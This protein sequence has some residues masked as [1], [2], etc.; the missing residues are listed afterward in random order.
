MSS[1]L[2]EGPA[3]PIP[4]PRAAVLSWSG[5]KD[6]SLALWEARRLGWG[7]RWLL[8]TVTEA[9][10]RVSMHGV[11]EEL[12]DEQAQGVGVE[13]RKVRIPSPCTNA[14]YE[15][16][17]GRAVR[18]L[19]AEGADAF[20]FGDLFLADVR[21]Y[22]EAHLRDLGVAALFPLWG[23]DTAALAR[24]FVAAG[25]RAYVVCL[26]PRRLDRAL[27]GAPFDDAFLDRLP[28]DVDPCG[29]R[30]EFHTFVWDGPIFRQ[31]LVVA[32]GEV[33]ERD[34]FVFC[35]LVAGP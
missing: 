32:T 21:A 2:P 1:S 26:D 24:T 30:G 33:V 29:E 18:E 3:A 15:A 34:G 9:Y 8:T 14:E 19:V 28:S 23:R 13:V 12:L 35:D 16:R 20:V 6:S 7:V 10:G 11:R 22:R 5:G 17:M 27:A 25:F 4:P 31:P